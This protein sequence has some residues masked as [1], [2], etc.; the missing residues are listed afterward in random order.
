[1]LSNTNSPI[2][3]GHVSLN[4]KKGKRNLKRIAESFMSCLISMKQGQ[5][6]GN[7]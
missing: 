4:R 7:A 1:M 3:V 2:V 5:G 6:R